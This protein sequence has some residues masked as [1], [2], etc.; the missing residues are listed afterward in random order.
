MLPTETYTNE[1][2]DHLGIEAGVCQEI[3]LASYLDEQVDNRQQQVSI[4]TTTVAMILKEL[5]F[6]NRRCTWCRSS[7]PIS[8]LNTY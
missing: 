4:G 2:L 5:G 8:P 6:S 1:R 3:R 7:W